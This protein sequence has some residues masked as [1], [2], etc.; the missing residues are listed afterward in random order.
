MKLEI[1]KMGINGEGIGY[2][3]KKPVFVMGAFP[4]EIVAVEITEENK[5]YAVG[6]LQKVIKRSPARVHKACKDKQCASCSLMGL[7]AKEQVEQKR[8]VVCQALYKYA[9]IRVNQISRMVYNEQLFHYRNQLKMPLH[10]VDGVLKCGLYLPNSNIFT[11]VEYCMIHEKPLEEMRKKIA[12]FCDVD[13]KAVI[14]SLDVHTLYEI[15]LNLQ[16]QVK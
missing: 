7:H 9:G 14:E 16:K 3:N 15:P 10:D 6:E 2:I 13:P 1:K 5:T 4:G 8:Q 11:P 12:L